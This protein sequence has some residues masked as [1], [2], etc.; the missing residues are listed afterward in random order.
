MRLPRFTISQIMI[1]VAVAGLAA[2]QLKGAWEALPADGPKP[3]MTAQGVAFAVPPWCLMLPLAAIVGLVVWRSRRSRLPGQ[4]R[5]NDRGY[6][7][8]RSSE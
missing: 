1:A 8:G 7:P 3:Q 6:L 5:R 2:C 4:F